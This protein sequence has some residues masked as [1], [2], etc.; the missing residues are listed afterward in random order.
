MRDTSEFLFELV[1]IWAV[2]IFF[3]AKCSQIQHSTIHVKYDNKINN[4]EI[5]SYE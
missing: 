1:I 4:K 2:M 5:K 3:G